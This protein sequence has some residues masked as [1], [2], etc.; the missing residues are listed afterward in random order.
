M[1]APQKPDT[2]R[3]FDG[4]DHSG[5]RT[6]S[7][8]LVSTVCL[9]LLVV[10][11]VPGRPGR[12]VEADTVGVVSAVNNPVGAERT[13]ELED[14]RIIEVPRNSTALDGSGINP[15]QLLLFGQDF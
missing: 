13:V 11:C 1:S 7:V 5:H 3:F 4:V 12:A 14:G 8:R 9:V 15:E 6:L 2:T 10:G